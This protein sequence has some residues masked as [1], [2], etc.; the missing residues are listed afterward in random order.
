[1]RACFVPSLDVITFESILVNVCLQDSLEPESGAV[2][3]EQN[4]DEG[5][6]HDNTYVN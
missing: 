3:I 1:M 5:G 2:L 4:V 6:K